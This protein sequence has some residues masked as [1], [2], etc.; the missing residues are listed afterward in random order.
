M[1]DS[2]RVVEEVGAMSA[3]DA[4]D[5]SAIGSLRRFSKRLSIRSKSMNLDLY[6]VD[7]LYLWSSQ[8]RP[9][10]QTAYV[11][12]RSRVCLGVFY[13]FKSRMLAMD[14]SFIHRPINISIHVTIASVT[15]VGIDRLH[16][17]FW[18]SYFSEF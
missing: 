12:C 16:A 11:R 5:K 2:S 3:E 18:Y 8:L 4:K 10:R 15:S 6:Q 14:Q 7:P 17:F 1:T 9:S 13:N